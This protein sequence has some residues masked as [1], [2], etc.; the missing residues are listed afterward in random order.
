LTSARHINFRHVLSN[1]VLT[2]TVIENRRIVELPL[3]GR[4][5]LKMVELT[6]N[7]AASFSGSGSSGPR[8]S[9]DRSTQQ[10]SIGG[11]RRE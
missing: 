6:P 9:G 4:N 2:S 3:N 11:G 10:L 8:Q 7:V 5:V 1:S